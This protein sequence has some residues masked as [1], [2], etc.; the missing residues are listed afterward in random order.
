MTTTLLRARR[1]IPS[2]RFSTRGTQCAACHDSPHGAQFASRQDLGRCE[3]CHGEGTFAPADR[4]DHDRDASF[5]LR[6]AH[7]QVAC[8]K[9]HKT[10]TGPWGRPM[11]RFRPLASTCESCHLVKANR[12]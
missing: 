11:V 10:E 9:C 5:P 6:G 4:F 1:A 12:S 8:A 3:A 2:L 7:A